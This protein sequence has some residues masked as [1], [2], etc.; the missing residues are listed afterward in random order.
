MREAEEKADKEL[1][2]LLSDFSG[3][4]NEGTFAPLAQYG[5]LRRPG[6]A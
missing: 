2:V 4:L 1:D 6:R 5:A 3:L